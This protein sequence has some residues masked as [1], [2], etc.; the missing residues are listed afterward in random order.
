MQNR[1][2]KFTNGFS[3]MF[4]TRVAT[5]CATNK[6]TDTTAASKTYIFMIGLLFICFE[7]ECKLHSRE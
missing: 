2:I 7:N 3:V 5:Q 6:T 1:I 4:K